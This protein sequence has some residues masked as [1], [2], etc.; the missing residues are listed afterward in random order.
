MEGFNLKWSELETSKIADRG[1]VMQLRGPRDNLPMV[2]LDGTPATI[3]VYGTDGSHFTEAKRAKLN[4]RLKRRNKDM[5]V[6]DI[7]KD[8]LELHI[9]AT[10]EWNLDFGGEDEYKHLRQCTPATVREAYERFPWM[11]R[12]VIEWIA[13]EANF[14]PAS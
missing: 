12:Q 14:T 1:S 9:A 11:H 10:K 4:A 7:E 3:T 6:E 8:D 2:N 13:S 5:A